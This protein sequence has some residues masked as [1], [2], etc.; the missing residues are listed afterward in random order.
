MRALFVRMKANDRRLLFVIIASS[1]HMHSVLERLLISSGSFNGRRWSFTVH[2]VFLCNKQ[3]SL[4][5]T[6]TSVSPGKSIS[7]ILNSCQYRLLV[8]IAS[9]DINIMPACFVK[10]HIGSRKFKMVAV[11]QEIWI[12]HWYSPMSGW[13]V[14]Q[15][16]MA[17]INR[18]TYM[19]YRIC[20]LV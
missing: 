18:N 12:K 11:V 19:Q 9:T 16:C 15:T 20:Q 10:T 17:A 8:D 4:D 3:V 5:L 1:T 14:N 7:L 13:L 2:Y 6:G